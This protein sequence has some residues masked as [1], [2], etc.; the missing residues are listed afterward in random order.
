MYQNKVLFMLFVTCWSCTMTVSSVA[1]P[2]GPIRSHITGGYKSRFILYLYFYSTRFVSYFLDI[3]PRTS[4]SDLDCSQF[5]N[6]YDVL[7]H[8]SFFIMINPMNDNLWGKSTAYMD[9]NGTLVTQLLLHNE[10]AVPLSIFCLLSLSHLTIY[11]M[12]FP[13]GNSSLSSNSFT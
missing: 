11:N 9:E 6:D 8:F 2:T 5:S 1:A 12:P 13:N 4:R 7:Y 10:N 3:Q